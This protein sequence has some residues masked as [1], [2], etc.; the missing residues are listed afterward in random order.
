MFGVMAQVVKISF[1][2]SG[3]FIDASGQCDASDVVLFTY[4]SGNQDIEKRDFVPLPP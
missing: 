3:F 4:F 2:V 1:G